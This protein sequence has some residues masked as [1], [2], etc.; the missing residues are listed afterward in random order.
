ML[1]SSLVGMGC[2]P[3]EMGSTGAAETEPGP[4]GSTS[5]DG[6]ELSSS[7]DSG[8]ATV[9]DGATDDGATDS[10]DTDGCEP[11]LDDCPDSLTRGCPYDLVGTDIVSDRILGLTCVPGCPGPTTS[12]VEYDSVTAEYVA[13]TETE[14][15]IIPAALAV[16]SDGSVVVAGVNKPFPWEPGVGTALHRIAVD[17]TIMWIVQIEDVFFD[18]LVVQGDEILGLGSDGVTAFALADGAQTWTLPA[19]L[20]PSELAAASDGTLY[21]YGWDGAAAFEGLHVLA[22]D[23]MH[24]LQWDFADDPVPGQER[25]LDDMVVD[26]AGGV[27]LVARVTIASEANDVIEVRKLDA[28][29]NEAWSVVVDAGVVTNES[30]DDRAFDVVARA[31]GGVIVVGRGANSRGSQPMAIA[32]DADGNELWSELGDLGPNNRIAHAVRVGDQ[33]Y[34]LGCGSGEWMVAF[35]P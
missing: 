32:F 26:E 19:G 14:P 16:A 4:M 24:E 28:A 11:A 12:L 15:A 31:G 5:E 8:G 3:G 18:E 30:R 27:V 9:D 35:A 29:G 2:G 6:G 21:V 7:S 34:G 10:G 20:Q 13:L 22:F 17:G 1:V 33:A 23:P 25:R